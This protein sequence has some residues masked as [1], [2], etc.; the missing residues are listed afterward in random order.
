MV[1]MVVPFDGDQGKLGLDVWLIFKQVSMAAC[2]FKAHAITVETIEQKPIRL[3]VQIP[4]APP[5]AF[6]GMVQVM[7]GQGCSFDQQHEDRFQFRQVLTASLRQFHIA[8]E[9]PG[10]RRVPH[11]NA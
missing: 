2:A 11:L 9:L 5:I 10:I 6:Q 1:S 4:A 7:R 8:F 3:D